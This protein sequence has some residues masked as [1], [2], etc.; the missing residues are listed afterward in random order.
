MR[1]DGVVITDMRDD[2][3]YAELRLVSPAGSTTV[4]ARPSDAIN[5]AVRVGAPIYCDPE[6]I[7]A[8]GI[9]EDQTGLDDDDEGSEGGDPEELVREFSEFIDH[10]KPEDFG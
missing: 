4:S 9:D 5:L 8:L 7:D 3:F 2:T 10:I 1:L 6:V